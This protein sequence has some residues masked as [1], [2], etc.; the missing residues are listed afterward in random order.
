MA[1]RVPETGRILTT[2]REAEL[3]RGVLDDLTGPSGSLSIH[4]DQ[5]TTVPLP[6]E[7]GVILQHVL[8]AMARGEA[9]TVTTMP[10]ELT[11]TTAAE[12]LGVSRPTLSQMAK[13][14]EIPSHKVGSHT[15]FAS[16]DVFGALRAR[17]ERERAAFAEL[18]DLEWLDES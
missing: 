10:E 7:V 18:R 12:I 4:R 14:G 6:R 5:G 9:V 2:D 16:K 1:T 13:R 17:R 11:T 8:S 15:R 3:A